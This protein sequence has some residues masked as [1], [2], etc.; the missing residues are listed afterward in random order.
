MPSVQSGTGWTQRT[1]TLKEKLSAL[2]I[3]ASVLPGLMTDEASWLVDALDPP[4]KVMS[5]VLLEL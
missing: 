1:F 3:P 2:D 5:H 4:V